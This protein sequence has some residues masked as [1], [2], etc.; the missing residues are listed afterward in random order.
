MSCKF[1][2]A[3]LVL[4]APQLRLYALKSPSKITS[5]SLV[6]FCSVRVV[7]LSDESDLMW[8]CWRDIH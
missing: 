1:L 6:T 4:C 5:L 3:V 7:E 8:L 2:P